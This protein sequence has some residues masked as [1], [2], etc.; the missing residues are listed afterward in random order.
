[1]NLFQ[2]YMGQPYGMDDA[3]QFQMGRP[4]AGMQPQLPRYSQPTFGHGK[5]LMGIYN[6]PP[7]QMT[8]LAP[9]GG[10][11]QQMHTGGEL[12]PQQMGNQGFGGLAGMFRGFSP[13]GRQ[14]MR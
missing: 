6:Q 12:Q 5:G 4:F 14:Y 1:M 2:H 3:D 7:G 9:P 10:Y 13:Y 11:G 8:N